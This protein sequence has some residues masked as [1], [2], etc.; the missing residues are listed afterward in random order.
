MERKVG[1]IPIL[2]SLRN[3]GGL[4][5]F[6]VVVVNAVALGFNTSELDS[7]D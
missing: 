3:A 5:F 2:A 7:L 6:A 4:Y 1:K